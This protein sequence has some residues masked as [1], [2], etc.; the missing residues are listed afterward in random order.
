MDIYSRG[1]ELA[2]GG[3]KLEKGAEEL[4]VADEDPGLGGGQ[5]KGI[6]NVI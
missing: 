4:G 2:G 3:G 1:R 6:R 5:P